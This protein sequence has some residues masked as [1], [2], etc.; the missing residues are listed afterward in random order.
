MRDPRPSVRSSLATIASSL[1]GSPGRRA[2]T[3]PRVSSTGR[4]GPC[5]TPSSVSPFITITFPM[6]ILRSQQRHQDAPPGG[7]RDQGDSGLSALYKQERPKSTSPPNTDRGDRSTSRAQEI[8][9][10]SRRPARSPA[11]RRSG[12]R[13]GTG[14]ARASRAAGETRH[15]GPASRRADRWSPRGMRSERPIQRSM[16]RKL[17]AFSSC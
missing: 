5:I 8:A 13:L 15:C 2:Q 12:R 10:N 1:E 7:S 11:S 14:Q 16:L 9:G 6:S 4:P 3:H 17:S